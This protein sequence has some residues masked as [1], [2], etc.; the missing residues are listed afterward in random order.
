M[1]ANDYKHTGAFSLVEMLA[2]IGIISL[3]ISLLMPSLSKSRRAAIAIQCE[4]NLRQIGMALTTYANNNNNNYP[5][6]AGW[7]VYPNG[8]SFDDDDKLGW[9]EQIMPVFVPPTNPIYT[10][11]EFVAEAKVNYFLDVRWLGVQN[12]QG[13]CLNRSEIRYSSLFILSGDC[14]GKYFYPPPFGIAS[15]RGGT[16]DIDKSDEGFKA[17]VFKGESGGLNMHPGGN[18]VLF[19]D[20]HV[21][22]F[23]AFDPQKMTYSPQKMQDW[24][25]CTPE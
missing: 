5:T 10:C 11:P 22:C 3:L 9:T 17:L 13:K 23:P 8:A 16:T 21:E 2:V 24:E 18:N 15:D 4:S 20:Q 25:N 14:T 7:E 19:A 12:P 1:N 6:W